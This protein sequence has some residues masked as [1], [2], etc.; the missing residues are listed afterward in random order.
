MQKSLRDRF[1]Q[2]EIVLFDNAQLM[3]AY[4]ESHLENTLIIALD[5]D[6]ELLMQPNGVCADP[7]T[8]R[9][10]AEFLASK[11]PICPIVI[12]TTNTA[13]GDGMEFLLRDANWETHR[14]HPFGDLEWISSKWFRTVRNAIVG[15]ARRATG[16]AQPTS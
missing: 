10:V 6:L 12:H 11:T 3:C 5:H 9:A 1:H 15:T 7:G 2:Y 16:E 14:V 8:G 13:A 4:L